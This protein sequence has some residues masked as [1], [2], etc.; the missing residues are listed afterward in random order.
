MVVVA[1][2]G[3]ALGIAARPGGHS[4][5]EHHW[6]GRWQGTGEQVAQPLDLDAATGQGGVGAAPAAPVDWFQAQVGQRRN[7]RGAQQRVA[8]LEQ[9]VGA[10]GEAGV[11]LGSEPAEAREGK[12]G[13]GM[14]AQPASRDPSQAT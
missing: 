14:A 13:I 4:H 11:Q 8:Q 2:L 3:P 7:R 5:R 10:T 6:V 12:V 9:R 1:A